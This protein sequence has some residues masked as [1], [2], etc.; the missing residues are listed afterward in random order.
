MPDYY[1]CDECI[2]KRKQIERDLKNKEEFFST[3]EEFFSTYNSMSRDN[4]IYIDGYIKWTD[5]EGN[6]KPERYLFIIT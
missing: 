2:S 4:N 5:K 6:L 1:D 3:Y